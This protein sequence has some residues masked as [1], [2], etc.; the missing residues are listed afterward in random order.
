MEESPRRPS[1]RLTTP[2][3]VGWCLP[4]NALQK[5]GHD[6]LVPVHLEIS[7]LRDQICHQFPQ[8]LRRRLANNN[9]GMRKLQ[10][11][12]VIYQVV[13]S[14]LYRYSYVMWFPQPE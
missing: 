13:P 2:Y 1:D 7:L 14:I 6:H 11:Q 4:K 10:L 5:A 9:V 12:Q 3:Y 8:C